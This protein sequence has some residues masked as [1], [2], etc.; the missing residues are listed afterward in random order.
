[1]AAGMVPFHTLYVGGYVVDLWAL[2]RIILGLWGIY[3]YHLFGKRLDAVFYQWRI[4]QLMSAFF[5]IEAFADLVLDAF[6]GQPT[7]L[8]LRSAGRLGIA[9]TVFAAS[10]QTL[11]M[12]S[13]TALAILPSIAIVKIAGMD[14]DVLSLASMALVLMA[15]WN[16]SIYSRMLK[17]SRIQTASRQLFLLSVLA[18]YVFQFVGV[19]LGTDLGTLVEFSETMAVVV[20]FAMV[21]AVLKSE[22]HVLAMR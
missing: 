12:T 21:S 6:G 3:N 22:E 5:V 2:L 13:A 14:I 17:P 10:Q 4:R 19:L 9:Y 18:S 7:F 16:F 11:K 15:V 1:M 20:G 8:L